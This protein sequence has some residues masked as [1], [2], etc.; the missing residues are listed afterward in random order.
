MKPFTPERL[1]HIRRLRK[2]RRLWKQA[3]LLALQE[4]QIAYPDYTEAQFRDDL[5]IRRKPQSKKRV[6]SP[7][8]R[9]GRHAQI[10][11]LMAQY[12]AT[13]DTEYVRQAMQLRKMIT[14]PYRVL[15]KLDGRKVEFC[16]SPLTAYKTIVAWVEKIKTCQTWSAF[17]EL[18]EGFLHQSGMGR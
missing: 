2:A 17:E 6:K 5:R 14:Q 1:N 4:M 16:Y 7:L 18:H 10:P 12:D 13:K 3:P 15:V 8:V 9:Y 11:K